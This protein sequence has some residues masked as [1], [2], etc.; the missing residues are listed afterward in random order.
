LDR[1]VLVGSCFGARTALASAPDLEGLAGLV[2]ISP[3]I[4]DVE[5][6]ERHA[7]RAA[8]N[9]TL[10]QY[11]RRAVKPKTLRAVFRREERRT[12]I[13][14]AR[15]K[16]TW[17]GRRGDREAWQ[18]RFVIS[19]RFLD[20][21]AAVARRRIPTL[22]VFGEDEDLYEDFV[23]A[24]EGRFGAILDGAEGSVNL[25]TLPGRVHGF[26]ALEIQDGV[27]EGIT[28]WLNGLG[29]EQ[30]LERLSPQEQSR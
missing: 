15:A 24:R 23:R 8:R 27:A 3:P 19:R 28:L 14:F 29:A 21:L 2:L 30:S 22:F 16:W 6:G 9:A 4:Q 7:N 17:L 25:S 13:R 1:I 18:N 12:Y 10:G 26:T 5:M 20:Q 11:L